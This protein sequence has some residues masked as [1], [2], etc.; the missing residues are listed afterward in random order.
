MSVVAGRHFTRGQRALFFSVGFL[1]W[2]AS[3]WLFLAITLVVVFA[4]CRRQFA[5]PSLALLR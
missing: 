3:A 4:L 2:F 1:G 5:F